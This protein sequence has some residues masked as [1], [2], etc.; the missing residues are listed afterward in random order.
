LQLAVWKWAGSKSVFK[1]EDV[2][3][4]WTNCPALLGFLWALQDGDAFIVWKLDRLG[5][6][7]RELIGG[8][9]S[10]EDLHCRWLRKRAVLH[11]PANP[12]LYGD[13][14]VAKRYC[15]CFSNG[16]R[17]E[18]R[19]HQAMACETPPGAKAVLLAK[20]VSA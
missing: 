3:G 18:Q 16:N 15:D 14:Q 12:C 4:T 17:Y 20:P 11:Q 13:W 1:D 8:I 2:S 10:A 6:Y 19:V 7:E 9:A 5:C